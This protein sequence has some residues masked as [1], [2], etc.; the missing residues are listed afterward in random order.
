MTRLAA[1]LFL[2]AL[3]AL[4]GFVINPRKVP[5]RRRLL[6]VL[7]SSLS[8]APFVAALYYFSPET[9]PSVW[10][11]RG[12]AILL[13]GPYLLLTF[14]GFQAA[15]YFAQQLLGS[16]WRWWRRRHGDSAS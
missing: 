1:A 12:A 9:A 2:P 4:F 15:N 11:R 14:A 16:A 7:L 10:Y 3:G 13:L 8:F 5:L 6:A